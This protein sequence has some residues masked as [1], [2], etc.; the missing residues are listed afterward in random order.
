MNLNWI[1]GLN[2]SPYWSLNFRTSL[3]SCRHCYFSR[4]LAWKEHMGEITYCTYIGEMS[5]KFLCSRRRF[6][7][8]HWLNSP[9]L[10]VSSSNFNML[11]KIVKRQFKG[12]REKLSLSTFSTIYIVEAILKCY[13]SVLIVILQKSPI[14]IISPIQ[15]VPT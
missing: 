4:S 1:I 9:F 7:L 15:Y 11:F 5:T 12:R 14:S 2:K 10:L 8:D 13:W 3:M 6:L